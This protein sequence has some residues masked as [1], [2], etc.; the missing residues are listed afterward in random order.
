MVQLS[1]D[2]K[3]YFECSMLNDVR[4]TCFHMVFVI[5]FLLLS[6][7]LFAQ[8]RSYRDVRDGKVYALV[9]INGLTWF[10]ENLSYKTS[11]SMSV[12]HALKSDTSI[13]G[14]FY[15]LEEAF[16]VCPAGWR[17]PKEKEVKALLKSERK[18]ALTVVDT[19][20]VLLCGRVDKGKHTKAGL[21]NTYWMDAPVQEGAILHWHVFQAEHKL[22][23]HNVVIAERQFPVRC[24]R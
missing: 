6:S 2:V 7:R 21:Q 1:L 24:V 8:D 22:H 11:T 3:P 23:D 10:A 15:L 16:E 12:G 17:L 19:L 14:E 20:N 4:F 13:C 9:E 18:G 5:S